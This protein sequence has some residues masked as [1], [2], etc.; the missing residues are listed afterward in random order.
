MQYQQRIVDQ[1]TQQSV[2][3]VFLEKATSDDFREDFQLVYDYLQKNY[4]LA[5]ESSLGDPE[6]SDDGYQVLARQ[7]L[8]VVG[9]YEP[10]GLPCFR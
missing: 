9:S 5:A 6:M 7:G 4:R 8:P 1:L 10:W 2:P 3:L